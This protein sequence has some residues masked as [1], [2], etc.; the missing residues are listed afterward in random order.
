M[1]CFAFLM[2]SLGKT[3]TFGPTP[4]FWKT[5]TF[6]LLH[7]YICLFSFDWFLL[8]NFCLHLH[9]HTFVAQS[10]LFINL[11]LLSISSD[12][13]LLPRTFVVYRTASETLLK[14]A[15]IP[16]TGGRRVAVRLVAGRGLAWPGRLALPHQHHTHTH[17]A[18]GM[19]M[20]N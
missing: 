12:F 11:C 19:G 4:L 18:P 6:P 5:G 2:K 13:C 3:D 10:T 8:Q 20:G 1:H 16:S 7:I 17:N 14:Q 9:P 15:S